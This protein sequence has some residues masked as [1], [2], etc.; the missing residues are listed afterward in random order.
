MEPYPRTLILSE[1][2][3]W[4]LSR[5][6]KTW[7]WRPWLIS[8]LPPCS[9]IQW[10]ATSLCFV[11][12]GKDRNISS[13]LR[14]ENN[15]F[16]FGKFAVLLS[17]RKNVMLVYGLMASLEDWIVIE[18]DDVWDVFSLIFQKQYLSLKFRSIDEW[19]VHQKTLLGWLFVPR[20]LPLLRFPP[21]S[22]VFCSA[23]SL[24]GTW[25]SEQL[26]LCILRHM[27]HTRVSLSHSDI[28]LH[29]LRLQATI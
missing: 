15:F 9:L 12:E 5:E 25:W 22:S 11:Q 2:N 7:Q 4:S 10:T 8:T 20:N 29:S 6:S 19:W 3:D 27:L 18:I 23:L 24:F 26:W 1:L 14:K 21:P 28:F 17:D 13:C 16:H